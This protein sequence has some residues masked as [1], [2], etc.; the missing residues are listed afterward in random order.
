MSGTVGG[1]I[2]T[3]LL[4]LEIEEVEFP[5]EARVTPVE[6]STNRALSPLTTLE[7]AQR[8]RSVLLSGDKRLMTEGWKRILLCKPTWIL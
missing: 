1:L 3:A 8:E 2:E 6:L 5:Q 4:D 7:T